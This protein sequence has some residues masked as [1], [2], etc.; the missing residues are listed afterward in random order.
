MRFPAAAADRD[1]RSSERTGGRQRHRVRRP[2]RDHRLSIGGRSTPLTPGGWSDSLEAAWTVFDRVAASA[3][4][5]L[6]KGPRGGGR[7]R[8]KMI[9]HVIESEWRYAREIGL[10]ERRAVRPAT[11]RAVD[12]LREAMLDVLRRPSRRLA[13]GGAQ[14]G[15]PATRPA[16]SR[17]TRSIM[18]GR[19]RTGPSRRRARLASANRSATSAA[20][21]G[22]GASIS[23]T[24]AAASPMS[25]AGP[26]GRPQVADRRV[27]DPPST[28]SRRRPRRTSR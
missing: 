11:D 19:W 13:A 3:P 9:A 2:V 17:G 22:R 7:D 20:S 16:G 18:P 8:D 28:A 14:A 4:A 6:R 23:P 10:R 5:E 21:T 24:A 12:A 27:A 1:T 26:P 25:S 15:Q